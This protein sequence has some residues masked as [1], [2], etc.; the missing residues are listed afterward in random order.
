MRHLIK[1]PLP[2]LLA[3]AACVKEGPAGPPGAV[4]PRG[5][6]GEQG[7]PGTQ[8]PTGA[9]GPEGPT[10]GGLYT[11]KRVTYKIDQMGLYVADGGVHSG[12]AYMVV[13]CRQPIDLPLTGSCDGQRATDGVV[14]TQNAPFAWGG[15]GY[16]DGLSAWECRWDFPS[17]AAQHDLPTVAAHIVCISGTDAGM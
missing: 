1:L 14:L 3:F 17:A 5:P 2:L 13:R 7:A 4:G 6:Q 16:T 10:G 15:P 8:G 9:Q 11:S 12:T